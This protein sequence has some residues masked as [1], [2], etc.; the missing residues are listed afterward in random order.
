MNS[1]SLRI[2]RVISIY[3]LSDSEVTCSLGNRSSHSISKMGLSLVMTRGRL[4]FLSALLRTCYS[5]VP[6]EARRSSLP[7]MRSSDFIARRRQS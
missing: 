3:C 4:K 1:G 5:V 6:E 7:A 2:L